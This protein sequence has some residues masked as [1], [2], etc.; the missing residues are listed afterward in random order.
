LNNI[1]RY[2]VKVDY[3]KKID[4]LVKEGKYSY[5]DRNISDSHYLPIDRKDKEE[6]SI[7]VVSISRFMTNIEVSY[8]LDQFGLRDVN[9]K[10]FLS[11]CHQF[12][13]IHYEG[14][15]VA[16]VSGGPI[17]VPYI[18]GNK[19]AQNNNLSLFIPEEWHTD[20]W[21]PEYRFAAVSK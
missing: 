8:L 15:I 21:P 5:V 9:I 18:S 4:E 2:L 17:L 14:P 13:D 20:F 12:P 10:Q 19:I 6:I 16:R 7:S 1:Y 11:L 3:S